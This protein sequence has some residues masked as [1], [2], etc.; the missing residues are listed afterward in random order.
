VAAGQGAKVQ[1]EGKDGAGLDASVSAVTDAA[2]GAGKV[3][4]L[5]LALPDGAQRPAFGSAAQVT[6]SVAQHDGVL[7]IPQKAV[8]TAG[9]RRFVEYMDGLNRRIADVQVGISSGDQVE[10]TGGLTEG[11]SVLVSQ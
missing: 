7:I 4:E 5:Q 1:I 10:V 9:T 8:R 6:L 3:A 2:S 11:Q